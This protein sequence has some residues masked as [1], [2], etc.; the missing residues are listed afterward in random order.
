MPNGA[1]YVNGLL[2]LNPDKPTRASFVLSASHAATLR[3]ILEADAGDHFYAACTSLVDAIRG[4]EAGF[5]TWATVK[6]YYS[7]FYSLRTLLALDGV[8]IVY[9]PQPDKIS[10][11]WID[12]SPGAILRTESRAR[13]THKLTLHVFERKYPTHHL[14][15]N[16]IETVPPLTWLIE[17]REE[18]NY[19]RTRFQEP[20]S[21]DHFAEVEKNGVRRLL[22][23]YVADEADVYTFQKDHAMLAYPVAAIRDAGGAL[24]ARLGN[25]RFHAEELAFLVDG[26]CDSD[27]SITPLTSIFRDL[28]G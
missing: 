2:G 19:R 26:C 4:L 28:A 18:S 10:E 6:C 15:S 13:G 3:S 5:Y 17:K 22:R 24:R 9:V 14:L 25:V 21:P 11:Y 27:G 1:Q 16:P 7:V 23:E 8:C 20:Q 12:A